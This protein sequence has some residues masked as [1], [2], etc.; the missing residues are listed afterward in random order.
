ML[1]CVLVDL[2]GGFRTQFLINEQP[3]CPLLAAR[4]FR[5]QGLPQA[6]E[7]L[8][9]NVMFFPASSSEFDLQSVAGSRPP[10]NQRWAAE[11]IH[12]RHAARSELSCHGRWD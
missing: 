2:S 5:P 6:Q 4:Q 11:I 8:Q 12:N 7:Q 3:V 9:S 10:R 1:E